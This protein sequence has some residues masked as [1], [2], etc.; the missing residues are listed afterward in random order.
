MRW[1]KFTRRGLLIVLSGVLLA[2]PLFNVIKVE[3]AEPSLWTGSGNPI[4]AVDE[5]PATA[6]NYAY[7]GGQCMNVDMTV[8][9]SNGNDQTFNDCTVETPYGTLG[10]GYFMPK[11]AS[12]AG[13][14][15]AAT[16][17]SSF[18]ALVPNTNNLYML[19]NAPYFGLYLSSHDN[20]AT[21]IKKYPGGTNGYRDVYY[22]GSPDRQLKDNAGN[23]IKINY[24]RPSAN[25]KWMI[26]QTQ[27]G[28]LIRINLETFEILPFVQFQSIYNS[29]NYGIS[30]DGRYAVLSS[31]QWNQRFL[32][33]D[34]STC[35]A[36]PTNSLN[37]VSGCE[38]KDIS[39]Y[40]DTKISNFPV[41]SE[42][43][44]S[45]DSTQ[46]SMLVR[47][48]SV[49][50][51]ISL[52]APGHETNQLDY[53]ALGDSFSSGEGDLDSSKYLPGTD[54]HKSELQPVSELCH[55]STRSYP[56]VLAQQMGISSSKF[57]NV[58]CSGARVSDI[59]S[60]A[61]NYL[62]QDDR[63]SVIQQDIDA[64]K[65]KQKEAL[66]YFRPGLRQQIDFVEKYQPK[67]VTIS[68]GG[69]DVG[70]AQKIKT[71][72]LTK[73][74]SCPSAANDAQKK[75]DGIEMQQMHGKLSK[76]YKKISG[77]SPN[78]K[79]YVIGYPKFIKE[80]TACAPNVQLDDN[81]RAMANQGV[82][83]MNDVIEAATKKAGVHYVS[84]E[85]S[86]QN[87]E[88]CVGAADEV[89]V[90]GIR[91][92]YDSLDVFGESWLNNGSFHPN[93]SGQRLIANAIRTSVGTSDFLA[94][95]VC[96]Q[97]S[98]Q[99]DVICPDT[100]ASTPQLTAY[101][102]TSATLPTGLQIISS[103]TLNTSK[104]LLKAAATPINIIGSLFAP[105]SY[106]HVEIH[107]NPVEIGDFT[108]D[109]NG[110][111][112]IST[113]LPTSVEVGYHTLRLYGTS[114]SG[115]SLEVYQPIAIVGSSVDIDGDGLN[116]ASDPCSFAT[117]SNVD[118]DQDGIDDGCDDYVTIF[119][120]T[121]LYRA[122][123]GNTANSEDPSRIYLERS[124]QRSKYEF[125][126][127]DYD[128]DDDGWSIMA[129]S[130]V[131]SNPGV[132]VKLIMDN[133]QPYILFKDSQFQCRT[134][135]TSN[136]EEIGSTDDHILEST[137]IPE[138][139]SCEE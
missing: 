41:A 28:V 30:P 59:W 102:N 80:H 95:D 50:K 68:I 57:K 58:A 61:P 56:F 3:A 129:R 10:K 96:P 23:L 139:A 134:L 115:E 106:I 74:T 100:N 46:I 101:Y 35:A 54:V 37:V 88:L 93:Q 82:V 90:N 111:I 128:P 97:T 78:T 36:N 70:F 103:Y 86:L 122:R 112:N 18:P 87:N 73:I 127:F 2:S 6:R 60:S 126:F 20:A 85:N 105:G 133:E 8:L 52:T 5:N 99:G 119:T 64:I 66:T 116:D 27:T 38:V 104:V 108:A 117:E 7:M 24:S 120:T 67:M 16:G 11:N 72:I 51:R 19:S 132:F 33:F 81:E 79:I 29:L 131:S 32:L 45:S 15:S 77:V 76:I 107:S 49:D 98:F 63:L 124:I 130:D 109:S 114:M 13:A 123:N 22:V 121:T 91:A 39:A 47:D 40:L 4:F 92:G 17:Y 21:K 1:T 94:Y 113:T 14:M 83:Y 9:M 26:A 43:E 75:R 71:C 48:G 69:N 137:D 31:N 89:A 110:H 62:G 55:V 34:L 136:L 125:G 135:T 25:G 42:L 84:I 65:L 138:G 44:F 12:R 53:L 118:Q